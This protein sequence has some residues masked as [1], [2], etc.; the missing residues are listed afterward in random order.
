[1]NAYL[2]GRSNVRSGINP[3]SI[4]PRALRC[5]LALGFLSCC[6]LAPLTS[7][8][9]QTAPGQSMGFVMTMW[10]TAMHE[11]PFMDECPQGPTPGNY[12]L[13]EA[14]ISPEKRRS[15]PEVLGTQMRWLTFRGRKGED[16]CEQPMS[17][18]DPPLTIVEGKYSYGIDLDGNSDGTATPKSCAHRTFTGMN[19]EAGVDNQMYRLLGCIQAWRST[20]HLE[21]NA[22]SQRR[23]GGLGMI[24]VEIT[25]VDDIRNDDDVKVTFYRGIGSFNLDSKNNV[26]PF[27]S[28]DID[29]ENGKPR[30]DDT[31]DGRISN[32]VLTT[33]PADVRLPLYG[34]YQ[35][36]NQLIRDMRLELNTTESEK[37]AKG[38]VYGYYGVEQFYDYVRGLLANFPMRHKYSSPAI[39]V[40][41][42]EL[43][44]GH[45]DP[46]TGKCTTFSSAFKFEAVRAFINHPP[47]VDAVNEAGRKTSLAANR[48]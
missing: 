4:I 1:M 41:A 13:W 24:L 43:A 6:S 28:Y 30:Y 42:H 37:P 46:V 32:G 2:N 20:G 27:G 25:G 14:S 15:Y 11:T 10:N 34:N 18:Q 17:I 39:Y 8:A 22:N 9:Q 48:P 38:M 40:A 35:Y 5:G 7:A 29:I 16:V 12:E 33:Q 47:K 31:V 26:L 36:L 45:P 19:G 3:G 23:T 44:D 21:T